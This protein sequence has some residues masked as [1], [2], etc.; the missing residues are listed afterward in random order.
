[1]KSPKDFSWFLVTGVVGMLGALWAALSSL[2]RK[3][4]AEKAT[5]KL[6]TIVESHDAAAALRAKVAEAKAAKA[7]AEAEQEKARDTVDVAN[8]LILGGTSADDDY[9]NGER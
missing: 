4:S 7:A 9:G 8:D 3:T 2:V 5:K 6:D 1:M